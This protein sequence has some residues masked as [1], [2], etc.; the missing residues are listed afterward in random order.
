MLNYVWLFLIVL[1]IGSALTV[2]LTDSYKGKYDKKIACEIIK[3]NNGY[4][5]EIT[6]KTY[7]KLFSGTVNNDI[8][9]KVLTKL[10]T[11]K[12]AQKILIE[13]N[14]ELKDELNNLGYGYFNINDDFIYVFLNRI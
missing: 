12:R 4:N 6:T 9:F 3:D 2:D 1:G 13:S 8:K 11:L 14:T 7:N 5:I 10:D